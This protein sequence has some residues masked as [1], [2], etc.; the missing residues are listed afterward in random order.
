MALRRSAGGSWPAVALVALLALLA[1]P[2]PAGAWYKHVAS[3][4]YHTVGR[5]SG[6]LMGV[7][8]SPYLWR[9]QLDGDAR[10]GR[11]DPPWWPGRPLPRERAAP[12]AAWPAWE[13]LPQRR[14]GVALGGPRRAKRDPDRRPTDGSRSRGS[15]WPAPAPGAPRKDPWASALCPPRCH[16]GGGETPGRGAP[17]APEGLE[18]TVGRGRWPQQAEEDEPAAAEAA[19]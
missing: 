4:R 9:R 14:L 6:L 3:P 19:R 1:G 10:G 8:R 17:L 16:G 7:R 15:A 18:R 5:A 12:A 2:P 13:A 11:S